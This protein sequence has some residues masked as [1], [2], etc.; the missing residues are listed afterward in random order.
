MKASNIIE[1]SK[2]PKGY[3]YKKDLNGLKVRISLKE[4][5]DFKNNIKVNEQK[6]GGFWDMGVQII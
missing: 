3:C 5:N 1:Y 2:S 6:G 4:F